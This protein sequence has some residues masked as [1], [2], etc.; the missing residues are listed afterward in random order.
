MAAVFILLLAAIWA[1]LLRMGWALPPIQSTLAGVHGPLIV[2]GFLGTLITLERAVAL[3]RPWAY[4]VP[5]VGAAGGIVLMFGFQAG[6]YLLAIGSIGLIAIYV[7]VLWRQTALYTVTMAIG[8]VA[9]FGGNVIWYVTGAIHQSVPWWVAFLVLT[10]VG[11]R[12][13]ISRVLRLSR[14]SH[15]LF[16]TSV[17][18]VCAGLVASMVNQVIG[19]RISAF[20]LVFLALWLLV[21][22]VARRTIRRSGIT[23]YI[24][25][26]L[27]I[28]Y[29]WLAAGG[30]LGLVHGYLIA[31]PLY[32]AWLHAI[33]LGFVF[34]MIFAHAFIILPAVTGLNVPYRPLIF[35]PVILMNL[36]LILRVT[37]D[38]FLWMPGRQWGGM[39]NGLAIVWFLITLACIALR[40]WSRT[41]QLTSEKEGKR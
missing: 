8:A 28:G 41:T 34:S 12:L 1:G 10:I 39:I 36:G 37:S 29:L 27:L 33:F 30:L 23:R 15:F 25:I 16:G 26:N 19:I 11:E 4:A 7:S 2:S 22:D 5:V 40:N 18:L 14:L 9:W 13:E 31:G 3:S 6:S 32:D 21:Y 38:L 20:G 35:G 17:G 24:A